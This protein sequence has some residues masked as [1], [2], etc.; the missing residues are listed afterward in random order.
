MASKKQ[1]EANRRNAKKS[2]G[3]KTPAGKARS[4]QNALKHGLL[5]RQVVLDDENEA[6]F[7]ELRL[8]LHEDLRPE[9]QLEVLLVNRIAAQQWRLARVPGLESEL[10]AALRADPV[11]GE[12][13]LGAAWERDSGPYGGALARLARYETML[14]RSTARLLAELRRVQADRLRRERQAAAERMP[15][16]AGAHGPGPDAYGLGRPAAARRDDPWPAGSAGLPVLPGLLNGPALADAVGWPGGSGTAL[17]G[18]GRP[19]PA[20]PGAAPHLAAPRGH[21]VLRNEADGMTLP[22]TG[23]Y[24]TTPSRALERFGE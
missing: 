9:G 13:S 19:D 1:I 20:S 4:A 5:S 3:P 18:A 17:P 11:H 7:K 22:G 15:A 6:E 8:N 16:H 24:L 21:G 23:G 12:R 14:E 2:T 10:I